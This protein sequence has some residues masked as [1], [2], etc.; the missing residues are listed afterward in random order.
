[1]H[2]TTLLFLPLVLLIPN[3][4]LAQPAL[5]FEDQAVAV[6]GGT[7]GGEV[8]V[9]GV[10]RERFAEVSPP[11]GRVDE[12]VTRGFT[13]AFEG[14]AP[15]QENAGTIIRSILTNPERLTI[16]DRVIDAYGLSG[17]GVRLNK[18]TGE[19]Q[20]FLESTLEKK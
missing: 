1:M 16:R 10:Y 19:F 7:P 11:L 20:A 4:L 3:P 14:V 9:W 8:V 6:R 18:A 2:W 5:S 13:S 17:R 12:R 15:T